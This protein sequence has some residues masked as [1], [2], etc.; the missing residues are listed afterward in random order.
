MMKRGKAAKGSTLVI[1]DGDDTLWETTHLYRNAK[2]AISHLIESAGLEGAEWRTAQEAINVA[3]TERMRLSSRQFPESCVRAYLR[4]CRNRQITPDPQLQATILEEARR[5]FT[6]P[7]RIAPAT[8]RALRELGKSAKIVLLTK[9]DL[10]VQVQRL[11]EAGLSDLLD[12]IYIIRSEKSKESFEALLHAYGARAEDSWSIGNSLPSDIAP[13][14]AAGLQCIHLA[15]SATWAYEN[16][17]ALVTSSAR[18]RSVGS[19]SDA[20]SLVLRERELQSS[21]PRTGNEGLA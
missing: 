7:V 20:V 2:D 10:A 21:S 8:V 9:G 5:V 15:G 19:F 18:I 1:V 16:R 4:M 3:L 6:T 14:A 13:A 12:S 11:E 17:P